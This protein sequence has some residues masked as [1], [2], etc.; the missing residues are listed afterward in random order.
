MKN[1]LTQA[2]VA[3]FLSDPSAETRAETAAKI[4]AQFNGPTLNEGER[5]LAEEIFRFMVRDAEVRVR[6]ALSRNLKTSRDLPHD[7]A[8]ALAHDVESV[9]LPMLEASVVL[10]D[11]D[12]IEIIRGANPGKQVAIAR[13]PTVSGSVA[14]ALID[15]RHREAVA[16]LV[17]ND[18]A[19]L[20]EAALQRVIDSHHN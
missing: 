3:R 15:S 19:D 1:K 14:D 16:T 13:R 4:A 11:K 7:V 20:T 8:L 9:A 18:G 12:L 6:E 5:R 2:E 10:T 17:G